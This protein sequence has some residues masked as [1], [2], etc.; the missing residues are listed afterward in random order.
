MFGK[1][2][3]MLQ[4]VK[5]EVVAKFWKGNDEHKETAQKLK[6]C[7]C[8]K[9]EHFGLLDTLVEHIQELEPI[10]PALST[11]DISQD[12]KSHLF[13]KPKRGRTDMEF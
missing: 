1:L 11:Y 3:I 12:S 8:S 10:V 5:E 7:C 4:C 13:H 6:Y 9:V 2:K